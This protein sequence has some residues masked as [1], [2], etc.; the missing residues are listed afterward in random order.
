MNIRYHWW[1]SIKM[2]K[3]ENIDKREP[4][5]TIKIGSNLG[6]KQPPTLSY[7]MPRRRQALLEIRRL[8]VEESI[9]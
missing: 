1:H 3:L 8:I 7:N 2:A 5:S 4:D 6:V 9:T